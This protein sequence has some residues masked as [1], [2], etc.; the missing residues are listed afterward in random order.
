MDLFC[1]TGTIGL[2]VAHACRHVYGFE[3]APSSIANAR[4]NADANG[5]A[6]ATFVQADLDIAVGVLSKHCPKPDVVITGE[7]GLL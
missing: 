7:L 3:Y 2:S 4:Q 6:N 5:I 1:G